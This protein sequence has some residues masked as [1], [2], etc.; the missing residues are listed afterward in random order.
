MSPRLCNL[1]EL[2]SKARR[3][4][5]IAGRGAGCLGMPKFTGRRAFSYARTICN[6]GTAISKTRSKAERGM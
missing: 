6:K 5:V 3:G 2:S 1:V 4:S